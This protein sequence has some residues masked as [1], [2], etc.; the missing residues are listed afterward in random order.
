MRLVT[1]VAMQVAIQVQTQVPTP[2]ATRVKIRSDQQRVLVREIQRP[3]GAENHPHT[4]R[5][6]PNSKLQTLNPKAREAREVPVRT[7]PFPLSPSPLAH[8][9]VVPPLLSEPSVSICVGRCGPC[10]TVHLWF[11]RIW[12]RPPRPRYI[13]L[14]PSALAAA[15]PV[16]QYI[17]G[18]TPL[19]LVDGTP[20]FPTL[21]W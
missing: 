21:W 9:A 15:A 5:E 4:V 13:H 2:V 7:L 12:L 3:L 20:R 10:P 16:R 1:R 18:F 6:I 8:L 19:R 14:R 11:H 17:C